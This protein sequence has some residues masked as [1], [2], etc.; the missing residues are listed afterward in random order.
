[1]ENIHQEALNVVE[2]FNNKVDERNG[3]EFHCP[4]EYKSYGWKGC[5]IEFMGVVVWDSEN[6]NRDY[7]SDNEKESLYD[8][9]ERESLKILKA[10]NL[11]MGAVI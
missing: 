3:S 2:D 8:Y 1:M 4:F 5:L 7:I 9:V 6:D 10:L 11:K